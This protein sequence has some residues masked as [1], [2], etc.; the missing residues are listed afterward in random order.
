MN[1]FMCRATGI[2][3]LYLASTLSAQTQGAAGEPPLRG[4]ALVKA[5]IALARDGEAMFPEV[6]NVEA[7]QV[8]FRYDIDSKCTVLE[9][10][11]FRAQ[12]RKRVAELRNQL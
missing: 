3:L 5:V 1:N 2:T 9:R 7:I 11:E 4:Q 10:D 6:G 8:D 12:Q